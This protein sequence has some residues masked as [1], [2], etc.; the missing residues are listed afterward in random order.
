[1]GG[2]GGPSV[3]IPALIDF[4]QNHP[5]T[6]CHLFGDERLVND[7]LE[8]FGNS[9][10]QSQLTIVPC[11]SSVTDDE[12]PSKILRQ[13]QDSSMAQAIRS[14]GDGTCDACVSAGN[15][16]ALMA[17]GIQ[18]LGTL[19]G[20]SRP[21]IC[22]S[23]PTEKGGYLALDLGAN[24]NCSGEQLYQF[25]VLGASTAEIIKDT[26]EPTVKL[27]N[28]G[29]ENSKGPPNIQKAAKLI[30]EDAKLNF[31]G[32]IE[33]HELFHT[34]ADVVVCDG[35]SGNIA[36]KASE[37]TANLIRQILKGQSDR[38]LLSK[39]GKYLLMGD[40]QE[41]YRKLNP[42]AYNGA[43]LLGLRGSLIKSHGGA[44]IEAFSESINVARLAIMR[45]LAENLAFKF[46]CKSLDGVVDLA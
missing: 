28:I 38:D 17:F 37:G 24:L 46:E 45:G 18:W 32:F 36:L 22:G 16:G 3:T 10:I 13:K 9:A 43:Y 19:P 20:T 42:S 6:E 29:V 14:I 35:W 33:A 4:L 2:D 39:L 12:R 34:D 11:P 23:M 25:A 15:T 1:M 30:K 44:D 21:A 41:F 40:G 27:L 26:S 7:A 5:E 31:R 8:K